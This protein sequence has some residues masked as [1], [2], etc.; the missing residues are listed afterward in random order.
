MSNEKYPEIEK[1]AIY[2]A[3]PKLRLIRGNSED[4]FHF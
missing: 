1:I 4:I 3:T 2:S